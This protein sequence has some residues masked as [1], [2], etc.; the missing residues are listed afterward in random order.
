VVMIIPVLYS[1]L[2]G[3]CNNLTKA[4]LIEN[5]AHKI[6]HALETH[7]FFTALL[8]DQ[9]SPKSGRGNVVKGMAVNLHCS[10]DV[11]CILFLVLG[12]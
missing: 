6:I 4:G 10:D 9:Q 1:H 5:V 11:G 8:H 2:C 3:F 12:Q 7:S